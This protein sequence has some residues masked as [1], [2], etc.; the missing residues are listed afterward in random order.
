[1][2]DMDDHSTAGLVQWLRNQYARHK[3]IEDQLAADKLEELERALAEARAERD[4]LRKEADKF[5][6]GIDW[7]QRALQ[8][9]A[10]VSQMRQQIEDAKPL[11]GALKR[12]EVELDNM[13]DH[14]EAFDAEW[15]EIMRHWR[16]Q[17]RQALSLNKWGTT[18]ASTS[19]GPSDNEGA[20]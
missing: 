13:L 10:A 1:M 16:T 19:A 11:V 12:T 20:E 2:S 9:E 5:E 3:E 7:I 6:D 14:A 4:A 8:A 18:E 17:V 15:V